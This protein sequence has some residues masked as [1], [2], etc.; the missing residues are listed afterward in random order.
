MKHHYAVVGLQESDHINVLSLE[1]PTGVGHAIRPDKTQRQY[2]VY[3]CEDPMP[4]EFDAAIAAVNGRVTL[5][6]ELLKW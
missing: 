4:T 3:W 6:L 2:R 1:Q 5:R